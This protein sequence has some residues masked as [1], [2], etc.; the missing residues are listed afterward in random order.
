M[1]KLTCWACCGLAL[2]VSAC[3]SATSTKK[4]TEP[5]THPSGT[6]TLRILGFGG[7]PFG[8]RVSSTGDVL[9]TEQ[10][11]N[12][13]VHLDSL[14]QTSHSIAVGRDPGDVV[15]NHAGTA[16]VSNFFD[17]T[18]SII[19]L[20]TNVV[21]KTVPVA[22]NNAYRLAFNNDE[23]RLYVTSTDGHL[24]TINTSSQTAGA[25]VA[26]GGAL[27]GIA[28]AHSGKSVFVTST[29]GSIWRLD[30]ASLVTSNSAVLTNCQAQD[31]AIATDDAELY[32]ACE[33]GSV[34]VVDPQTLTTKTTVT[35]TGAG[36]FGLAVTP[37]NAQLYVASPGSGLVTILDRAGR[38]VVKSFPVAGTPRRVAFN[39]HGDKAYI[40]NEGNWVDVIE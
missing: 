27:Q 5:P 34:Q 33:N 3:S 13:A 17:G 19:D 35:L 25:S 36:P 4:H 18:V 7:R 9:V 12:S 11:L 10:D 39:A 37:D 15:A 20:A 28:V 14:A 8:I 38:S 29:S 32:V 22:P 6:S 23:S 30:A 21:T 16:F 31:V 2:V 40:A 24:Y 26:L 1:N